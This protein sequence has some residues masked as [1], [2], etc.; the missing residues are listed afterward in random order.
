MCQKKNTWDQKQEI[1]AERAEIAGFNKEVQRVR[2]AKSERARSQRKEALERK[3]ANKEK[4]QAYQ[5]I[6]NTKNIKKMS[7]KARRSLIK[8]PKAMFEE[9]LH[10]KKPANLV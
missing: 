3:S 4:G 2:E 7:K 1:R 9:F 10:G 8:M 6:T 5:L